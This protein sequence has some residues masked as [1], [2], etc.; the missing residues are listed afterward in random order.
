MI[1]SCQSIRFLSMLVLLILL[2][3]PAV[4]LGQTRNEKWKQCGGNDPDRTIEACS[5]LIQSGQDTGISLAAIF[6]DRGLAHAHKGDYD[7]AINL[8]PEVWRT[9]TNMITTTQFKTSIKRCG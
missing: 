4:L 5:A 2:G 8:M 3:E 1:I 6:Y 9:G 7:L